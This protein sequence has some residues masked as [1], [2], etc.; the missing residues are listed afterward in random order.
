MLIETDITRNKNKQNNN[1]FSK[2]HTH[3]I[4]PQCIIFEDENQKQQTAAAA[5]AAEYPHRHHHLSHPTTAAAT[6]AAITQT[7]ACADP[8]QPPHIQTPANDDTPA[9]AAN[10]QGRRR[11]PPCLESSEGR[12]GAVWSDSEAFDATTFKTRNSARASCPAGRP[13]WI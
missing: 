7:T 2:E 8:L 1:P 3:T 9:A 10:A 13:A 4:R 6:A 5:A 12:P 11:R